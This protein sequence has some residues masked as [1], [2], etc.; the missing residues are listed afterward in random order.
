MPTSNTDYW[1]KKLARNIE[2]DLE[3]QAALEELGWKVLTIWECEARDPSA[4]E[5][6]VNTI[7]CVDDRFGAKA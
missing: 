4:L 3:K 7:L 6:Q 5:K 2:R 1:N